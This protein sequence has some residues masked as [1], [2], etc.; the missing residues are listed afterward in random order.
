MMVTGVTWVTLSPVR[1]VENLLETFSRPLGAYRPAGTWLHLCV[2][3]CAQTWWSR[4]AAVG[5]V[6]AVN[7]SWACAAGESAIVLCCV[8]ETQM[9]SWLHR[10]RM[11]IMNHLPRQIVVITTDFLQNGNQECVRRF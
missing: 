7:M 8:K 1:H 6:H 11:V 3:S 4:K 9:R 10:E 5:A 2:G